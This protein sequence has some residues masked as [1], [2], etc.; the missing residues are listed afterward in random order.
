MA[1]ASANEAPSATSSTAWRRRKRRTSSAVAHAC[2][3]RLRSRAVKPS[4]GGERGRLIL[5]AYYQRTILEKT[6]GNSLRDL[7]VVATV[8]AD[9]GGSNPYLASDLDPEEYAPKEPLTWLDLVAL[10]FEDLW[11][12]QLKEA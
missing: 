9:N 1:A 3:S 10:V 12:A 6:F 4:S 11:L 2:R 7:N 8:R 5:S